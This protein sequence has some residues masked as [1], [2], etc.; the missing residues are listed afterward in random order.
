MSRLNHLHSSTKQK[1]KKTS[2]SSKIQRNNYTV[3]TAILT[4]LGLVILFQAFRWQ[5]IETD[6]FKQLAKQQY[7]DSNIKTAERGIIRASDGTILAVDQ[8]IWNIYATLSTDKRERE[9][10]FNN[11]DLF[12][13]TVSA[14]LAVERD[15]IDSKI[16]DNFVYAPL[17]KGVDTE[18]KNALATANIFGENKKGFG[19]YFERGVKR[20][21]PN[22]ELSSHII[23]FMGKDSN[24][25]DLGQYG[26]E[27]FYFGDITG[28]EGYTYEEKDSRGNT[29]LT[30]EYEPVLPRSGK[31]FTLTIRPS[32]QNKVEKILKEG[33]E[34]T[35]AKSGTVIIMN[36]KTGEIISMANYP[37][38]NPNEY[39][40][41][42]DPWIF[43]N[44]AVSD[45]YEYGSVQKPITV[46]MALESG[47][48]N[49]DTTCDDPTGYLDLFLATGYEDLKGRKIYT[50]DK[51]PDGKQNFA[52]MLK[53]S[54]NPCIA[55][56][57]LNM[58]SRYYYSKI[59][60]FGIGEFIGIGLQEEATSFLK[61]FKDWTR[62]DIITTSY[63][64]AM[65]ATPLQITSALSTIA[66][67]GVRMRPYIISQISDE[68]EKIKF[69]P[70]V[71]SQ[72]ISKETADM[73]AEMMTHVIED[74]GINEREIKLLKDY[75]V[76]GKTG[77]AQIAKKDGVGYEERK[78]NTTFVGFAPADDAK[79][80]ML[81]RL[82][83]PKTSQYASP[84]VV[85]LWT[86]IFL[87]IAN[88][89]EI[90]KRN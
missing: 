19:L 9:L 21:Y 80:I 10:F 46:A 14:I 4:C 90:T 36:P 16:T 54:N 17:A 22:A 57:A 69:E 51:L 76:G 62:L 1:N 79:M 25:N 70:Q 55:K 82:E 49:K 52:D 50:W 77:T 27:G 33:V 24:G 53:N 11:K 8:P 88:D 85:P 72:P 3:V 41:V 29:I 20:I 37:T 48:A 5:V 43:K 67:H 61:P 66:N 58:D 35:G 23:G 30:S 15:T 31:D 26:V 45:V 71:L 78:T 18:K 86:E 47:S 68:K 59:K 84:T 63:G 7:Q 89:L 13:T 32:I 56:T 83:E 81:V 34:K 42:P 65:S 38:Y 40:R 6:K 2:L 39:W 12:V 60:E 73:V 64:Q 44:L 87:S 28:K 75:Y 74:G